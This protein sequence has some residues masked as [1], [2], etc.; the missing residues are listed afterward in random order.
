[1]KIF[2]LSSYKFCILANILKY[3]QFLTSPDKEQFDDYH[4]RI[5]LAE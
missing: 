5:P 2:F 4:Q 3:L 1:M